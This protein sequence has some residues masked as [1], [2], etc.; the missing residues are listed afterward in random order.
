SPSTRPAPPRTGPRPPARAP[1]GPLAG[2]KVAI[3]QGVSLV[4]PPGYRIVSRN[5]HGGEAEDSRGVRI[6]GEPITGASDDI[7]QLMQAYART[8]DMTFDKLVTAPIEG[9]KRPLAVLH[10]TFDGVQV[11]G[12]ATPVI[13]PGYRVVVAVEFPLSLAN[14]KG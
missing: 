5:A 1:T 12:I 3:G 6:Y 10:G 13:G 4:L 2:Q 7:Q 11:I 8:N 14:D 9:T